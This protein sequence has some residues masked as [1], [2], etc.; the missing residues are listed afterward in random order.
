MD[1]TSEGQKSIKLTFPDGVLREFPFASS[2]LDVARE[3]GP[4]LAKAALAIRLDDK[5]LD[6]KTEIYED[7]EF[8]VVTA[9]DNDALE[10]IRHDAAHVLAQAVL[11]VYAE[12]SSVL[13]LPHPS[14]NFLSLPYS[15]ISE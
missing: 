6:L 9:K 14:S 1:K 11:G 15:T 12:R 2:G 13:L 3:I 7:C 8:S 5:I 4:G 10:L